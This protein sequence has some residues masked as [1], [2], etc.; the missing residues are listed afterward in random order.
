[1]RI[2]NNKRGV[3]DEVFKLALA[4]IVVAAILALFA[5]FFTDI[6]ESGQTSINTTMTA[7]ENFSQKIANRTAGF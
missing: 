6:R 4:V 2:S 1:M 7:L 5:V 3:S